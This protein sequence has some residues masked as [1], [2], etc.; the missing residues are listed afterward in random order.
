[1]IIDVALKLRMTGPDDDEGHVVG[2]SKL[3][4]GFKSGAKTGCSFLL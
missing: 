4:K 3:K 1:M 2:R